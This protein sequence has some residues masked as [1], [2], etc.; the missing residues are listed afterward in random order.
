GNYKITHGE[1]VAIG[2]NYVTKLSVKQKRLGKD[3]FDRLEEL[4]IRANLPTT[5]PTGLGKDK[6]IGTMMHDKKRQG[7][8]IKLVLPQTRLGLVD[9]DVSVPLTE[10]S[11]IL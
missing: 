11:K 7:D 6:L 2:L 5:L 4:L 9:F 10:L 8:D 1:A 3:A